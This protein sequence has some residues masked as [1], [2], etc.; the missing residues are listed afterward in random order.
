MKPKRGKS[1]EQHS[2]QEA[3]TKEAETEDKTAK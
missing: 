1:N 3:I 2:E